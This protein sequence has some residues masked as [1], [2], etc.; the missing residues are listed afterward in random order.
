MKWLSLSITDPTGS[1]QEGKDFAKWVIPCTSQGVSREKDHTC[2]SWPPAVAVIAA[3]RCF[4]STCYRRQRG[5]VHLL[6]GTQKG[7][8]NKPWYSFVWILP[9]PKATIGMNSTVLPVATSDRRQSNF[10][11]NRDWQRC[12]DGTSGLATVVKDAA[13]SISCLTYRSIVLISKV[14]FGEHLRLQDGTHRRF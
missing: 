3:V 6:C 14:V 5:W 9:I 4:C 8:R 2:V 10:I 7:K 13:M 12:L 1:T 11:V